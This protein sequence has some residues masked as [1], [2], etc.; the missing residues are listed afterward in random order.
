MS[1][2]DSYQSYGN[3]MDGNNKGISYMIIIIL[4]T[5]IMIINNSL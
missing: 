2:L 3:H 5:I 1:L 4:H